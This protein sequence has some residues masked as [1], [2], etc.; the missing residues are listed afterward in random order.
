[1]FSA[2]H[3][4]LTQ[5]LNNTEKILRHLEHPYQYNYYIPQPYWPERAPSYRANLPTFTSHS[6]SL[7]SNTISHSFPSST[8]LSMPSASNSPTDHTTRHN[9]C[10]FSTPVNLI[11]VLSKYPKLRGQGKMGALAV[12]LA[13]ECFFGEDVMR[14]SSVG[15]WSV[16]TSPLVC[17]GLEEIKKVFFS[18]NEFQNNKPGFER[19]VWC[20]CKAA[21]DHAC[22]KYRQ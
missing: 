17:E 19:E 22:N 6:T 11:N 20:K 18:C 13:R 2:Q 7:P 5:I 8:T 10:S 1:M 16:G 12:A 4:L 21:I 3:Q 15:E 9:T 14:R